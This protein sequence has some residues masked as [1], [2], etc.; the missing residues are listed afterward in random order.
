M[1]AALRVEARQLESDIDAKLQAFSKLGRD[2]GSR[3]SGMKEPLMAESNTEGMF[4]SMALELQQLISNL[5]MVNDNMQAATGDSPSP[6]IS[7]TLSRHTALLNEMQQ[8]FTKTKRSIRDAFDRAGLLSSVQKNISTHQTEEARRQELQDKIS[9]STQ[10]I[11]RTANDAISIAI[12]A[13]DAL[14][15][16]RG[17]LS[18]V[19][20]KMS[21]IASKVPGLNNIMEKIRYRSQRDQ[22]II[23]G[24]VALCICFILWYLF[25]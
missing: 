18:K 21:N 19:S 14:V 15:A 22:Y 4:E 25:G 3:S 13:K 11:S 1:C 9:R 10:N 24:V 8:E 5:S 17:M 7:H 2:I 23:A 6:S 16:Q 12:A 20:S